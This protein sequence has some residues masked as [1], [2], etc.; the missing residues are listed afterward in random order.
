MHQSSSSVQKVV[1]VQMVHGLAVPTV[2]IIM[3][4][5]TAATTAII[6]VAIIP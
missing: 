2:F 5:G 3:T 1:G 6:A 4:V